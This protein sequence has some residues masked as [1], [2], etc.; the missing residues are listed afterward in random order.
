MP[1]IDQSLGS[2][3]EEQYWKLTGLQAGTDR[4]MRYLALFGIEA[5]SLADMWVCDWGCGPFG[6]MHSVL[7][8]VRKGFA[9]DNLWRVYTKWKRS[10]VPIMGCDFRGR[11]DIPD[12]S[13]DAA[14]LTNVLDHVRGPRQTLSELARILRPRGL[15]YFFVHLRVDRSK[16]HYPMNARA[17][18]KFLGPPPCHRFILPVYPYALSAYWQWRW[19]KEGYDR[20]NDEVTRRRALWGVLE[21]TEEPFHAKPLV[22]GPIYWRAGIYLKRNVLPRK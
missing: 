11:A 2:G 22:K 15:L 4:Y 5:D 19:A 3:M 6:G 12:G 9:V 21:R 10:P 1:E 20:V 13:C 17:V 8:G 7:Q 14:F 18:S 16:G